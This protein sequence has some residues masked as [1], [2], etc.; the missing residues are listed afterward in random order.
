MEFQDHSLTSGKNFGLDFQT[1]G[2]REIP[3]SEVNLL[4]TWTAPCT[5]TRITNYISRIIWK[6]PAV[7]VL[8]YVQLITFMFISG[9]LNNN[10]RTTSYNRTIWALVRSKEEM[11]GLKVYGSR[12]PMSKRTGDT[13]MAK[14]RK[15]RQYKG[16]AP[17][18]G[19]TE[20]SR[21]GTWIL[22]LLGTR[23]I[24]DLFATYYY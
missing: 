22:A 24:W 10:F 8:R 3:T 13:G 11:L 6:W 12:H 14:I 7:R 16:S 23:R 4:I 17:A 21:S 5:Q 19:G 2:E 9:K 20:E 1:P 15:E 18:L